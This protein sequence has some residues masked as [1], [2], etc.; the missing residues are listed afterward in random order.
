MPTRRLLWMSDS[1]TLY[2]GFGRVT[3]ELLRRLSRTESFEVAA[4]GWGYEGWPYSRDWI[5]FDV[6][7]SRPSVL[8]R[9]TL[10]FAVEEFQPDILVVLGDIW[11][12]EWLQEFTPRPPRV[13]AYVPV[14]GEPFYRSWAPFL[15]WVDLVV[16]C[17]A[18]GAGVLAEAVPETRLRMVPHGVDPEVFFP[19]P[20]EVRPEVLRDRFV[21][22]CVARN[23]PR[24]NLP[25]LIEGFSVFAKGRPD[26]L[27]YLHT[28]PDDVGWDVIDLLKRWGVHDQTCISAKASIRDGVSSRKLNE[29]YNYFDVMVLPT[30]GEGFGLPLL[31]AMSAG[32]PVMATAYSSCV[33]L[34]AGRGSLIDVMGYVTAG[35]HNVRYAIPDVGDL[36]DNL[37]RLYDDPAERERC[38]AAGR[39]FAETLSWDKIVPMWIQLFDEL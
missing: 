9:D 17:S 39:R 21:V 14:D 29:V 19:L 32:V 8:G 38:A 24:K 34:L 30:A 12:L 16:G 26:A 10:K 27:L 28:D 11:M 15:N 22:G 31:E 20:R 23:Q 18:F 33:E 25:A 4:L 6:Y 2:T 3:R 13:V 35:R 5:P 1:P 7:P 37:H 36:V